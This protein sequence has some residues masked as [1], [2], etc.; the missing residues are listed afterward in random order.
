MQV[1]RC[2]SFSFITEWKDIN[3]I[4]DKIMAGVADGNGLASELRLRGNAGVEDVQT[5]ATSPSSMNAEQQDSR[6]SEATPTAASN[7][8]SVYGR[9]PNGTGGLLNAGF[10]LIAAR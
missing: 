3:K 1:C 8:K 10:Q 2:F 6:S 7:K 5:A 4:E 9:T